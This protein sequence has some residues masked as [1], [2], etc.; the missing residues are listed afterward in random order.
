MFLSISVMAPNSANRAI[1]IAS[2]FAHFLFHGI[3]N[4]IGMGA[5]RAG[6]VCGSV[7]G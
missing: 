1:V 7:V 5:R 6:F 2:F 4:C 3:P